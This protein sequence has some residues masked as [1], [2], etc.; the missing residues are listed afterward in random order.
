MARIVHAQ[1]NFTAGEMTPRMKGRGDVARYQNGAETI[2]NGLVVVHGGV[3]RRPGLRYLA[4]AKHAG[5][6]RVRLIRYVFSVDQSYLLEVGHQYVRVFDGSS[7]AAMLDDSLAVLEIPSPYT[8]DQLAQITTKQSADVMFLFHPQVQPHQLRR[9]SPTKWVMIP[10]PWSVHPFSENGHQPD[11]ALTLSDET[12]G[13]GR[14]FT[15]NPTSVPDAPTI[16][17]ATPLDGAAVVAFTSPAN[18]GGM[19][20]THYTATSSPGGLTGTSPGG[21]IRVNGLTNGVAYTFTVTATNGVG[22][23]APSAASASVTPLA[24]LGGLPLTVSATETDFSRMVLNGL[25]VVTGPTAS[26]STGTGPFTYAWTKLSGSALLELDTANTAAPVFASEAY[27]ATN[28]GTFRC[29]VTDPL[30]ATGSVDVNV[31]IRHKAAGGGG[32]G[33]GG[34]PWEPI[35][36][37]IP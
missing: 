8:E 16:G 35:D 26:S 19:A 6:R 22:T 9:L 37:E 29:T 36:W 20:I 18:A 25:Q 7:G 13:A 34:G 1:T 23:G 5:A 3:M 31:S 27:A 14:T 4:T 33:G 11:A 10:V 24:G 21:Q 2:E 28:Y 12:P 17:T 30:G 15:T 32:G